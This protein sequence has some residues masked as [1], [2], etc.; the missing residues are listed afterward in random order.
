MSMWP[1]RLNGV[2]LHAVAAFTR[3]LKLPPANLLKCVIK[4]TQMDLL[5]FDVWATTKKK[6]R[7]YSQMEGVAHMS[8][9]GRCVS[10]TTAPTIQIPLTR[11]KLL[12]ETQVSLPCD[13]SHMS[14]WKV[15]SRD[16]SS[17]RCPAAFIGSACREAAAAATVRSSLG[18]LLLITQVR[19]PCLDK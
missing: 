4:S 16:H 8:T 14:T 3:H 12:P 7:K 17:P 5:C 9:Y 13:V 19:L 2:V 15:C 18:R 6:E 10:I 1:I 11:I